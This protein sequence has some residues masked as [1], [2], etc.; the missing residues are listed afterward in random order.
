M[1]LGLCD[2]VEH[3][4]SGAGLARLLGPASALGRDGLSL[5]LQ[6]DLCTELTERALSLAVDWQRELP[7]LT[8]LLKTTDR[9]LVY[10]DAVHQDEL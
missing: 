5:H 6:A 8:Y 10:A 2:V 4:L 7:L 3:I 9:V 1:R